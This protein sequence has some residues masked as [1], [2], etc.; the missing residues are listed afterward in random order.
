MLVKHIKKFIEDLNTAHGGACHTEIYTL[1]TAYFDKK[2]IDSV[3]TADDLNF[4]IEQF[5]KRSSLIKYTDRDYTLNPDGV[6]ALWIG[7][8]KNLAPFTNKSYIQILFPDAIN[9]LD[10]ITL[11]PLQ[12]TINTDNLYWGYGYRTLHRKRGL[13]QHLIDN[14][15]VLSTRRKV[16]TRELSPLSIEELTRLKGC[17]RS[18]KSAFSIGDE[19]FSSF[20]NF[21][22]KKVFPKLN[23]SNEVP[24]AL[25]P[26]LYL[27]L[28]RYAVLKAEGK[29]FAV[30]KQE[31]GSFF[32]FLY[33][34]QLSDV[35]QFYGVHF[36]V[37]GTSY[38]LFEFLI[39]LNKAQ[40]FNI[41]D[42][43]APLISWLSATY[44]RLTT[45]K[46]TAS[47]PS[48]RKSFASLT[49]DEVLDQCKLLLLSLFVV[50][51]PGS[52]GTRTISVVDKT[53]KVFSQAA[54][55]LHRFQPA[56]EADDTDGLIKLC[57]EVMDDT[58]ERYSDSDHSSLW[59]CIFSSNSSAWFEH[60]K[61]GTL[62]T[63]GVNW[64]DPKLLIHTLVRFNAMSPAVT[65]LANL[66][67]D[68]LIR[69]YCQSLSKFQRQMR[70]NILFSEFV[71]KIQESPDL[72]VLL[73]SLELYSAEE[74]RS[75]FLSN[76]TYHVGNQL[77]ELD[78][79]KTTTL[80][81]FFSTSHKM[82]SVKLEVAELK[83]ES[84]MDVISQYKR[85]IH[86]PALKLSPLHLE[87]LLGYLQSLCVPILT[88]VEQL[89]AEQSARIADPLGA[90]T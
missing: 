63:L 85:L 60:A 12:D 32:E 16:D 81:S 71:K 59:N 4:L 39:T 5:K 29:P 6:N 26:Y 68:E 13:C 31:L 52:W 49:N 73:L 30:F 35:N 74:Y 70:I 48:D 84:V 89:Q 42:Y 19:S 76:C 77:H 46:T 65:R 54:T 28:E 72:K 50:D 23:D 80:T 78:I 38:Y 83:I 82:D 25:I 75:N 51:F 43:L 7:L 62:S 9:T 27:L 17:K 87:K 37:K 45:K 79:V 10:P 33:K 90:P 15:F 24:F 56:I 8:A 20:W 3:L 64:Y 40:N 58:I 36:E 14:E 44:P 69:T 66:F 41:D 1:L 18:P 67:L 47:A 88:Y 22:Q 61:E 53:H 2:E 55:I 11:V 57:R 21:L 34:N 86:E